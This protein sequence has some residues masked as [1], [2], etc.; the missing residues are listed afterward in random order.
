MHSTKWQTEG[1]RQTA[2]YSDFSYSYGNVTHSAKTNDQT[3]IKLLQL[4]NKSLNLQLNSILLN[5]YS[6]GESNLG[7]HSDDEKEL[8]NLPIIVSLS[9]GVT[10]NFELKNKLTSKTIKLPL[11]PGSLL[12]MSGHTQTFWL[13]RVPM[14]MTQR[15]PRINLTFRQIFF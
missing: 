2:W 10:R 11:Q 1:R 8:G 3:L 9:L 12:I 13:H 4:I 14:D 7:W 6:S 5:L 15:K